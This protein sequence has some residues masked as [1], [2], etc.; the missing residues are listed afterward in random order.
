M[1]LE[2]LNDL[3]VQEGAGTARP[4]P[5][6]QGIFPA[7]ASLPESLRDSA[8]PGLTGTGTCEN[9][10]MASAGIRGIFLVTFDNIAGPKLTAEA[11]L[12]CIS[13]ESFDT[14]S[15]YVITQPSLCGKVVTVLHPALCAEATPSVPVPIT[16]PMKVMSCPI[17]LSHEVS[18]RVNNLLYTLH[19]PN[20]VIAAVSPKP[21]ALLRRPTP[22]A[23]R[24]PAAI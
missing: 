23:R 6:G 12:G 11:P 17:G 14:I 3:P 1:V 24:G 7:F 5:V 13:S 15:E 21:T 4:R 16:A 22:G 18:L 2:V 20:L 10:N 19:V 8:T 9:L